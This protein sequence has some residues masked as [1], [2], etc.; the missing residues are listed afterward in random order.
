V[1]FEV[2]HQVAD[3]LAGV[4]G[5]SV[6]SPIRAP[7]GLRFWKIAMGAAADVVGSRL[8]RAACAYRMTLGVRS[9]P[10]RSCGGPFDGIK[11]G[12]SVAGTSPADGAR[13]AR[14]RLR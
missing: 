3:R 2:V 14:G 11:A 12:K 13:P 4:L 5:R 1:F 9:K 7:P 8:L 6:S 10:S